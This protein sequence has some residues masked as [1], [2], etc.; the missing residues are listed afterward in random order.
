[1]ENKSRA[2]KYP[3]RYGR[4]SKTNDLCNVYLCHRE[5]FLGRFCFLKYLL[6]F[7]TTCRVK[8]NAYANEQQ[9]FSLG[10]NHEELYHLLNNEW[11]VVVDWFRNGMLTNPDKF[12]SINL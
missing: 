10:K 7:I 4:G 5:V 9:I 2:K 11:C 12:Q 8:L 3:R 6:L 1:M